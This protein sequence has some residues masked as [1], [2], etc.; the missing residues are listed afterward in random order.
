VA[1]HVDLYLS[2]IP[3]DLEIARAGSIKAYAVT[4]DTRLAFAPDI[5]T[6]SEMGLPALT[7]SSWTGFFAPKGTPRDIID[8]LNAAAVEALAEAGVRSRI[9]ALGGE[10]FPRERQTPEFL[11]DLQKA[12]PLRSRRPAWLEGP[13]GR[14]VLNMKEQLG[15]SRG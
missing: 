12:D 2:G 10:I 3:A 1:G 13:V 8:K 11:G 15:D 5:P 7:D 4:S 9:G 6:V 14:L